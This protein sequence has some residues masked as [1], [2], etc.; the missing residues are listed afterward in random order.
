MTETTIWK[1]KFPPDTTRIQNIPMPK[2]AIILSCG[3]LVGEGFVIWAQIDL[4]FEK[5]LENRS[6]LC[7]PTGAIISWGEK[8]K[9][10]IGTIVVKNESGM[11]DDMLPYIVHHIYET[12]SWEEPK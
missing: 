1:F 5:E 7:L 8:L 4:K 10:F 3:F 6:L 2:N 11:F 12:E 9:K